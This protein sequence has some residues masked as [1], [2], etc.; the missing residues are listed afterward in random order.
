M[1]FKD[2]LSNCRIFGVLG[3]YLLAQQHR[4]HAFSLS[5]TPAPLAA[6]C[7]GKYRN[8]NML[9]LVS[10]HQSAMQLQ[11][12]PGD[13]DDSDV[14]STILAN[15]SDQVVVGVAGTAAS[16]IMLYSEYVLS[17][18][19]CGLPAGPLGLV[20]AAEGI[21]YLSVIG[22][23]G[24]SIYTK[25]KT[26]SGLPAGKFGLLGLAE[27]LAFLALLAGVVVLVLQVMIYEYIPNAI[28]MEGGMCQ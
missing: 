23:G 8:V 19:G 7:F 5:P 18:T 14:P 10:N 28:P 13:N 17:Q 15:E 11:A 9:S 16:L 26:G 4:T 27:G 22:L 24:Y 1:F 21:S 12:S 6:K 25:V 2:N 3:L 20:G